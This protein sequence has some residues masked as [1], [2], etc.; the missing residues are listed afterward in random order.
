MTKGSRVVDYHQHRIAAKEEPMTPATLLDK[1]IGVPGGLH[2]GLIEYIL[3]GRRT[4]SFLRAV[5]ENNLYQAC[6][7]ADDDNRYRLYDIVFFLTN[8]AP[9]DCWQSPA[10]V[11]AW[12][13]RGGLAGR[14]EL[15]AV[16]V[17]YAADVARIQSALGAAGYTYSAIDVER[18]WALYS[19]RASA[20]W[21]IL[22]GY[23]D[24]AI[25]KALTPFL[26]AQS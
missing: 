6:A 21:L 23:D 18:L 8:Y 26:A 20:G 22:D 1:L 12:I 10:T 7:R 15:A 13:A 3:F 17:Q 5:L 19:A 2:E 16:D 11:D 4:G 24:A 9:G 14:T 25:V